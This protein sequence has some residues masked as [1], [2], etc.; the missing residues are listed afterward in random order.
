[1]SAKMISAKIYNLDSEINECMN[2]ED[3][4]IRIQMQHIVNK[5]DNVFRLHKYSIKSDEG[6]HMI[7]LIEKI[8]LI[9]YRLKMKKESNSVVIKLINADIIRLNEVLHDLQDH[10]E[11]DNSNEDE[12]EFNP[13]SKIIY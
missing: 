5:I 2:E 12:Y 7:Q 1:M 8:Q 9:L 3:V 10:F 4:K 6:I 11:T 13:F